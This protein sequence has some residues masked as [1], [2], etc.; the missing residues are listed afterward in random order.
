MRK[1]CLPE[2]LN[3]WRIW[4]QGWGEASGTRNISWVFLAQ[5][6]G[7]WA[8][9]DW[10][11][12]VVFN[13]SKNAWAMT[14]GCFCSTNGTE[15]K[16]HAFK[17]LEDPSRLPSEAR[18]LLWTSQRVFEQSLHISSADPFMSILYL[19]WNVLFQSALGF[20]LAPLFPHPSL[21]S[22]HYRITGLF[23]LH[24]N[25]GSNVGY[26][27]PF[28]PTHFNWKFLSIINLGNGLSVVLT[29]WRREKIIGLYQSQRCNP[30]TAMQT[31]TRTLSP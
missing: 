20:I 30:F 5:L 11:Y 27:S 29:Q 22:I 15:L 28:W 4:T 10:L 21:H 16:D 19:S 12:I 31:C 14:A 7:I 6:W 17:D 8:L 13:I 26:R 2:P 23:A 9:Q 25:T 24:P 18:I 1:H 3:P